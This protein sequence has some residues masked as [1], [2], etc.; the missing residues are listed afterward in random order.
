MKSKLNR[1][2]YDN[3]PGFVCIILEELIEEFGKEEWFSKAWEEYR[4]HILNSSMDDMKMP[5]YIF[6]K[7]I[8]DE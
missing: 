2:F 6:Q 3:L 8:K 7:Y 1:D 5:G 4:Q